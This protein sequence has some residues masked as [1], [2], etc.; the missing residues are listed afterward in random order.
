M[1]GI[2]TSHLKKTKGKLLHSKIGE[3]AKYKEFVN[4]LPENTII[5]VYMEV[6]IGTGTLGQLAKVHKCIRVL[7]LDLGY[8]FEDVKLLVKEKAGL[9]HKR[10]IEGKEYLD[11]KSFGNCSSDDLN[12]AIQACIEIG[13][14]VGS[15]LR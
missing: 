14:T 7:A 12:L 1:K 3:E 15:N 6:N 2:F 5:D 10:T 4:S 11:W 13:D 8:T 9:V